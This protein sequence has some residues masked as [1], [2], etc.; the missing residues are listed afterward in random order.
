[1]ATVT[2]YAAAAVLLAAT[3]TFA[4]AGDGDFYARVFGGF[5]NLSSTDVG[6]DITGNTGFDTGYLAGAAFG[7][8]YEGSPLRAELE[9]SYRS[10]DSDTFAGGANGDFASTTLAV[11]GYY[12]FGTS[13]GSR[14]TPY[15]GAGLAY[16]TEIDF[17][18][19]GGSAPGEYNDSGVF[20]YQLM[21]GASYAL[22]E[23]VSLNGELR[24]FDAGSQTLT[25]DGGGAITAD[26]SSVEA[27]FGVTLA[28]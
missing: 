18:I 25:S 21:A 16:V 2:K 26:Y 12:D 3:P 19:T 14:W 24:Y 4:V 11:N 28:F 17:D 15:V 6:R 10:A 27:V 23:R 22:S 5:S 20:G 1:M 8:D 13:A 7:Y 9:F